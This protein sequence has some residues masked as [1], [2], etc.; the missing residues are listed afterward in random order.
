MSG[1]AISHDSYGHVS[2]IDIKPAETA[3]KSMIDSVDPNL[4]DTAFFADTT[5]MNKFTEEY[6]IWDTFTQ[7]VA[8]KADAESLRG[9]LREW[10]EKA[11]NKFGFTFKD[12]KSLYA[13]QFSATKAQTIES[14][15]RDKMAPII[16]YAFGVNEKAQREK[17]EIVLAHFGDA[18]IFEHPYDAEF[19]KD[20]FDTRL[21]NNDIGFFKK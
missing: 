3:L 21:V 13:E 17:R 11:A 9:K 20:C 12:L 2:G 14:E 15:E 4:A 10:Q 5:P 19:L 16:L 18:K 7:F 8:T 1:Y 6:N